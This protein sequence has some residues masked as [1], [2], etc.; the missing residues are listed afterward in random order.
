[1]FLDD[2]TISAPVDPGAA[3]EVAKKV[4]QYR[5]YRSNL[6]QQ[7]RQELARFGVAPEGGRI[8]DGCGTLERHDLAR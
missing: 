7:D 3:S 4:A 6:S 5:P 1:L 2:K 8:V